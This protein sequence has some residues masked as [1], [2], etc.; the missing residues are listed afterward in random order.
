MMMK[1]IAGL[2]GLL[3]GIGAVVWL[4]RDRLI[5][6]TAAREPEP[7]QFRAAGQRARVPGTVAAPAVVGDDLKVVKGIGPVYEKALHAYGVRTFAALAKVDAT[8]LAGHLGIPESRIVD[9]VDQ[10]QRL[11]A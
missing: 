11:Q 4:M 10:A 9:W 6:L 1:R 7:P 2:F 5:S 8:D 3:S